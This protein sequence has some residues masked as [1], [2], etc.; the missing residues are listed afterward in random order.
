MNEYSAIAAWLLRQK[1][2]G[3]ASPWHAYIQS[4]HRHIPVP[5]LYPDDLLALS[6]YPFFINEVRGR[7]TRGHTGAQ[8]LE[9]GSP[10][11]RETVPPRLAH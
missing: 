8:Y 2:K 9:Q 11:S 6:E 3:E 10:V 1:A 4:L 7:D 5:F